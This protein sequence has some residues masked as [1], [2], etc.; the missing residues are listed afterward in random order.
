MQVPAECM[1]S[2]IQGNSWIGFVLRQ[3]NQAEKEANDSLAVI[4]PSCHISRHSSALQSH[5]MV[6]RTTLFYGRDSEHLQ[7]WKYEE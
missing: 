5:D 7:R 1:P 4:Y 6:P 3:A 2:D